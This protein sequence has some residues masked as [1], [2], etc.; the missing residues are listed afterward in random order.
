MGTGGR[1]IIKSGERVSPMCKE[2]ADSI[3]K[4]KG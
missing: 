1:S 2:G 4:Q 3:K